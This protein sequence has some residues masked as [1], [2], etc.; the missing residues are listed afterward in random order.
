MINSLIVIIFI[1]LSS[2]LHYHND[3]T[4]LNVRAFLS[5]GSTLSAPDLGKSHNYVIFELT[6]Q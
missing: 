6:E 3:G 2:V 1:V 4:V 5:D